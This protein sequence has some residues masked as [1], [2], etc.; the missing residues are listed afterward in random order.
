ME[1]R[2]T[3]KIEK[4]HHGEFIGAATPA[5]NIGIAALTF[6]V[7][8]K[9]SADDTTEMERRKPIL[10]PSTPLARS[11]RPMRPCFTFRVNISD[12]YR[13]Q[14]SA[15]YRAGRDLTAVGR[16]LNESRLKA[17]QRRTHQQG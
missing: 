14:W 17:S 16:A 3:A 8:R 4:D 15:D 12:G 5:V 2:W 9:S 6:S 1:R 7:E 13:A 11:D 10:N